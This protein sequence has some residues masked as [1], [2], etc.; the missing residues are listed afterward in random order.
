M[1]LGVVACLVLLSPACGKDDSAAPPSDAEPDPSLAF[2]MRVV[3]SSDGECSEDAE[4]PC[5]RFR[6]EFPRFTDAPTRRAWPR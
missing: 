1:L 3:E 2:E 5:A 6:A 4:S